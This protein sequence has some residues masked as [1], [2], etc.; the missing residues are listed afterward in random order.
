MELAGDEKRIQALFSE[1]MLEDKRVAPEFELLWH[2][3]PR[4]LAPG[5]PFNRSFVLVATAVVFAV[6]CSL[7]LWPRNRLGQENVA[8]PKAIALAITSSG[9]RGVNVSVDLTKSAQ[10]RQ[11]MTARVKHPLTASEPGGNEAL[12][13]SNWQSPTT[14]FLESP[15]NQ[16]L[17]STPQLNQSERELQT[18]LAGNLAE[19]R[20]Q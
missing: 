10:R 7:A 1:L 15:A 19:E 4:K 6:L 17:K 2:A 13:I 20:R 8:S 18:F 3:R 9:A 16:V 11:R 14:I 12:A 5:H